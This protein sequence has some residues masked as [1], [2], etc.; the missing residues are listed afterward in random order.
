MWARKICLIKIDFISSLCF[1]QSPPRCQVD[2]GESAL[3]KKSSEQPLT[4]FVKSGNYGCLR[5]KTTVPAGYAFFAAC[6]GNQ[7]STIISALRMGEWDGPTT[8]LLLAVPRDNAN[9]P[10]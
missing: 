2:G 6:R 10:D 9:Y 7:Y 5:R 4:E 3:G 8:E 1:P